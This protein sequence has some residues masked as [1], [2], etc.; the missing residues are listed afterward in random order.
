MNVCTFEDEGEVKKALRADF[1]REV[2]CTHMPLLRNLNISVNS[3]R[4]T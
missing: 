1:D 4:M 2:P 3:S